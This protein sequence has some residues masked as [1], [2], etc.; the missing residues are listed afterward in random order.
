MQVVCEMPDVEY[1]NSDDFT[2]IA[3]RNPPSKEVIETV[4]NN[5]R[6]DI[7]FYEEV[8]VVEGQAADKGKY[9]LV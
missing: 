1:R 8:Q 5:A 4:Y 3:K 9:F 7:R 6:F 2:G